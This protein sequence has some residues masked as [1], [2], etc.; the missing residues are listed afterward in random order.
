ML[1]DVAADALVDTLADKVAE[2]KDLTLGDRLGN[3]KTSQWSKFWLTSKQSL[4]PR[5][6]ATYWSM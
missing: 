2:E 3:V 4:S 5:N 6:L 1:V